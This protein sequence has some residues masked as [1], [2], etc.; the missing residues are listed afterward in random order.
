MFFNIII[1]LVINFYI[2]FLLSNYHAFYALIRMCH[3][4]LKCVLFL[5]ITRQVG[6]MLKVITVKSCHLD[7]QSLVINDV[8]RDLQLLLLADPNSAVGFLE[9]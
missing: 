3:F 5:K 8:I 9:F 4:L 6:F 1:L 7:S 2:I